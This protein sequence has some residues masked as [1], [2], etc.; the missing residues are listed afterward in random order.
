M[1]TRVVFRFNKQTGQVEEFRVEGESTLERGQHNRAHEEL[2][3]EI[4]RILDP[5]PG[6]DELT[7]DHR[8]ARQ[9]AAKP[10]AETEEQRKRLRGGRA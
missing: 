8:P 3:A 1:R 6:I 2:A 7:G 10:E 5:E 9:A 4:G